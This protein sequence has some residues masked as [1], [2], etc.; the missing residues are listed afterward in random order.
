MPH[1]C[2][3]FFPCYI[4]F[5][6]IFDGILSSSFQFYLFFRWFVFVMC[7][8]RCMSLLPKLFLFHCPSYFL[9]LFFVFDFY[10][11]E[12]E[13]NKL[14]N[15]YRILEGVRKAESEDSQN[16]IRKQVFIFIIYF[17]FSLF[18][19]LISIYFSHLLLFLH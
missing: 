3:F 2:F 12:M 4:I 7:W 10:L 8:F 15:Q 16:E 18:H 11:G 5:L 14:Q 13:L 19:S 17:F 9:L 6:K 1:D